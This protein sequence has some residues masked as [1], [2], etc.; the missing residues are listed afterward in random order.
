MTMIIYSYAV[1]SHLV[2]HCANF[3]IFN[4]YEEKSG[5]SGSGDPFVQR[6]ETICAV[7]DQGIMRNSSVKVF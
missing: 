5:D 7:F 4:F 2:T 6:N 1:N 3:P